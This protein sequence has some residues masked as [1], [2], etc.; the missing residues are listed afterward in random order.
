MLSR[1]C[2]REIPVVSRPR[3]LITFM[4]IAAVFVLATADAHARA[5][6]GFSAGSR[7]MRK[8]SA[9]ARADR[10][11]PAEFDDTTRHGGRRRA[12]GHAVGFLRRRIVRRAGC[13]IPRRGS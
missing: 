4:A 10:V 12:D 3:W 13:R 9:P 1:Q 11:A 7:G 6:S 5:G 2:G 8:Y